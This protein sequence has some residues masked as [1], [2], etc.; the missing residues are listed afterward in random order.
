MKMVSAILGRK[1]R[2]GNINL[3]AKISAIN[4]EVIIYSLMF[5]AFNERLY[6]LLSDNFNFAIEMGC[7]RKKFG[8]RRQILRQIVPINGARYCTSNTVSVLQYSY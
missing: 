7:N 5:V 3:A 4:I 1:W 8:V 2:S 6:N